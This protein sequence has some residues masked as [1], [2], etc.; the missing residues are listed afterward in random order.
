MI[1]YPV[2]LRIFPMFQDHL[3]AILQKLI[4]RGGG[5]PDTFRPFCL[6]QLLPTKEVGIDNIISTYNIHT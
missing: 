1:F 6:S 5:N 2:N 3:R 4:F